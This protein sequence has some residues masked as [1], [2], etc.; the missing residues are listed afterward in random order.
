MRFR[1]FFLCVFCPIN[2]LRLP[3]PKFLILFQ[4]SETKFLSGSKNKQEYLTW[5]YYTNY[6]LEI[7]TVLC[8]L[9]KMHYIILSNCAICTNCKNPI[10]GMIQILI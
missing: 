10:D 6:F 2:I 1:L 9:Y 4:F 7:N 8:Y 5:F 3:N